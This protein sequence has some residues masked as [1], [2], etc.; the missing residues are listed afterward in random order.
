MHKSIFSLSFLLGLA[1]LGFI[2]AAFANQQTTI[3]TAPN[4]NFNTL[5]HKRMIMTGAHFISIPSK[6][7]EP[8]S[9]VTD[10]S[11]FSGDD[12]DDYLSIQMVALCP[13]IECE[14]FSQARNI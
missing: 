7:G 13:C 5:F 8:A 4:S 2:Q 1:F 3:S 12:I 11:D 14:Y 6:N 9:I 10:L